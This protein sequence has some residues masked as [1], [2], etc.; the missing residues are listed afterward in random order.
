M[1]R[2]PPLPSALPKTASSGARA[3]APHLLT[4][5]L[6]ALSLS[7]LS[8]LALKAAQSSPLLGAGTQAEALNASLRPEDHARAS[9]P[10]APRYTLDARLDLDLFVYE[11]EL[12]VALS[13][14][15]Q[16]P[17]SALRFALSPNGSAAMSDRHLV[18]TSARVAGAE[19]RYDRLSRETLVLP[20]SAPIAPG[21][22]VVVELSFKGSLPRSH[23]LNPLAPLNLERLL[24]ALGGAGAGGGSAHSAEEGQRV[25]SMWRWFPLLVDDE[26][27]DDEGVG[28]RLRARGVSH[29]DVTLTLP[30][31]VEVATTGVEVAPR[32]EGA[33]GAPLSE[34]LARRRF[35]APLARD[36]AL[37]ASPDYTRQSAEVS[38]GAERVVRVNSYALRAHEGVGAEVMRGAVS[39]L[40]GF[41]RRF[42]PYPYTELDVVEDPLG[43]AGEALSSSGLVT[44]GSTLYLSPPPGPA[45]PANPSPLSGALISEA[46]EFMVAHEVAR[47]WWGV[48]VGSDPHAHPALNDTLA[49]YSAAAHLHGARGAEVAGRQVDLMMR[50]NYHL[51]RLMGA[52]DAPVDRPLSAFKTPLDSAIAYGK[53][54]LFLWN[55]RGQIGADALDAALRAHA[56]AGRF[57]EQGLADLKGRLRAASGEGGEAFDAAWG[58]WFEGSH[59]DEDVGGVSV[60]QALKILWG[61]EALAQL[62]PRARRWAE[63]EGVGAL[64]GLLEGAL[65]GDLNHERV[66]YDAIA[67]L[68]EDLM[69]EEP[70]VA[71]WAGVLGEALSAPEGDPAAMTRAL[72]EGLSRELAKDDPRLGLAVEG[73]GLLFEAL[74]MEEAQGEAKGEAPSAPSE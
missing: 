64:A 27:V 62:S 11:G 56:E 50:L 16:A 21:E 51:A 53:A 74:M 18:V 29:Y 10:S 5:T 15:T 3:Q 12:S 26:G 55:L 17:L 59:G 44:L 34:G 71:R 70:E 45:A 43:G 32:A 19:V 8:L 28:G 63:H 60:Y 39:A 33:V 30:E 47:Q 23:P 48:T 31:G 14:T 22:R 2:P 37:I 7:A 4:L 40:E 58:R 42:G 9:E 25:V 35:V 57:G 54:G 1:R 67:R 24:S 49:Q 6:R 52:E 65:R 66:D 69:R 72:T 20:L 41:E 13:N 61:E 73:V 38:L 36:F 46:R 68:L